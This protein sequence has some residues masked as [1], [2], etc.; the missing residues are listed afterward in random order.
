M[1][2]ATC[3]PSLATKIKKNFDR[4]HQSQGMLAP[5]P[6][7]K[8]QLFP[9][10]SLPYVQYVHLPV[11]VEASPIPI[12]NSVHDNAYSLPVPSTHGATVGDPQE[13]TVTGPQPKSNS[14]EVLLHKGGGL[15]MS[16]KEKMSTSLG[17]SHWEKPLRPTQRGPNAVLLTDSGYPSLDCST[18]PQPLLQDLDSFN[19]VSLKGGRPR[20]KEGKKPPSTKGV[21][22][23]RR[24]IICAEAPAAHHKLPGETS[25]FHLLQSCWISYSCT[26]G[27]SPGGGGTCHRVVRARARVYHNFHH[28]G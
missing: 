2:V 25:C 11:C 13:A 3:D 27:T 15:E 12:I 24:P 9:Q 14:W 4:Q 1:D 8:A 22:K 16:G 5:A 19:V 23:S 17:S 20:S 7:I 21:A 26:A 28:C 18:T 6:S 10:P